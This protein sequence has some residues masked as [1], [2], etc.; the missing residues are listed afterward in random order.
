MKYIL[1]FIT[2]S[3]I[4]LLATSCS[5]FSPQNK[6]N[7]T[8]AKVVADNSEIFDNEAPNGPASAQPSAVPNESQVDG[9][10]TLFAVKGKQI[11]GENRPV[12]ITG[13]MATTVAMLLTVILLLEKVVR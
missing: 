10:W 6:K 2:A 12:M 1:N 7:V 5:I 8:P 11:K 4:C 9:E 3:A 13:F